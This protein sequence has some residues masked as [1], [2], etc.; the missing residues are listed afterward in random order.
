MVIADEA[1]NFT[2]KE[3]TTLMTRLG[4]NSQLFICGDYMQ[5]DIN[6]KSGFKDMFDLFDDKASQK[7]G[8]QCFSFGLEDIKRSAILSYIIKKISSK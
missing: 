4:H 7:N 6:G 8:I 2:F 1:Q 3:L 5:S